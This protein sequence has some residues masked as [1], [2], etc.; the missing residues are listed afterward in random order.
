MK[1]FERWWLGAGAVGVLGLV[2][3]G[4]S[5][6]DSAK[7]TS[8]PIL[9]EVDLD[10]EAIVWVDCDEEG[11]EVV[12]DPVDPL[13]PPPLPTKGGGL[14]TLDRPRTPRQC[15]PPPPPRPCLP[16]D[17]P[18]QTAAACPADRDVDR[19][20]IVNCTPVGDGGAG[21]WSPPPPS[22]ERWQCSGKP[23]FPCYPTA[24]NGGKASH[25]NHDRQEYNFARGCCILKNV[26]DVRPPT[27][28]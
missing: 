4:L 8:S 13:P 9:A 10:A 27:C 23:H 2:A 25:I 14:K 1:T 26:A 21:N 15:K 20:D 24:A 17:V 12:S 22:T 6:N 18:A 7:G 28:L 5:T 16:P 11:N 3:C 19:T